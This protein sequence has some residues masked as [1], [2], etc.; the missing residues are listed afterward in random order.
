MAR[1][2]ERI[3][4]E[5]E[6]EIEDLDRDIRHM[7]ELARGNHR[8]RPHDQEYGFGERD[9]GHG[10]RLTSRV[11]AQVDRNSH[12]HRWNLHIPRSTPR[13]ES[14]HDHTEI[15]RRNG[16]RVVMDNRWDREDRRRGHEDI[17]SLEWRVPSNVSAAEYYTTSN[18]RREILEEIVRRHFPSGAPPRGTR[19]EVFEPDFPPDNGVRVTIHTGDD[20]EPSAVRGIS[21]PSRRAS[22]RL[23]FLR[24][25]SYS[26]P[27]FN[28][29]REGEFIV[30]PDTQQ[31]YPM[32]PPDTTPE[33]A[34]RRE[35]NRLPTRTI[36]ES[37]KGDDGKVSCAICMDEKHVGETV[38]LM[39][40]T[41][42]FDKNCIETWI[43]QNGTCPTCRHPVG[44][45]IRRG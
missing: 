2:V 10:G 26:P 40:C 41:H 25:P 8:S 36:V 21:P 3:R 17:D 4:D 20:E 13:R 43:R 34:S 22:G 39:P 15:Q 16:D 9:H 24:R 6:R 44:D 29:G 37:D 30:N 18:Y 1:E 14:I 27:D 11:D 28:R 38:T 7:G 45:G 31:P 5:M 33:P 12:H 35:I 42:F 23:G 32:I 19:M